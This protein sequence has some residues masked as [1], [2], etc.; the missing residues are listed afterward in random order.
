MVIQ[1]RFGALFLLLVVLVS[2]VAGCGQPDRPSVNDW[3]QLWNEVLAE[4]PDPDSIVE[5]LNR[6]L[7]AG[8]LASLRSTTG[9]LFPTPDLAVDSTVREWVRIAEDTF[10]ECPPASV[11]IPDLAAAY[12]ELARLEAE[13]AAAL[14]F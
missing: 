14:Q 13:V 8:V 4:I 1:R 9:E 2:T 12:R 5:P 3:Q 7:C 11:Q 6:D 10:F